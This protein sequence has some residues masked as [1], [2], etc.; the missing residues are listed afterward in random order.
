MTSAR[1]VAAI[2]FLCVAAIAQNARAVAQPDGTVIPQG[3]NVQNLFMSRSEPLNAL[4]D[5]AITPERFV[6]GC[7]LTFTLVTRD[8]ALFQNAFGWY[9]VDPAGRA[10]PESDLHVLIPCSAR[11]PF[12]ATLD[13]RTEAAY[14]GGEIGFFL[15]TPQQPGSTSSPACS[16][17][18][19]CGRAGHPGY[20]YYTQRTYN[21]DNTGPSSYIHLLIYDSRVTPQAFYFAWEDLYGGGDNQF[22]DFVA[23]VSNIV[24]AGAGAACNTGRPGVCGQGTQQCRSGMLTCVGTNTPRMETCDGADN[25]CDGRVDNGDLCPARFVCERGTCVAQCVEGSCFDGFA[26]NVRA[27]CVES[28]CLTVDCAEGQR[29]EAGRCVGVCDGVRCPA[30][31]LCRAGRC[32][33][34]C[35]GVMCDMDQ[36]CV[37]GVCQA[38]CEC[39]RC[40]TGETCASSG[41]CVPTACATVTCPA[42]ET[43]AMGACT[44]ACIGV[45]CPRG[46]RCER[47]ACVLAPPVSGMDGGTS[48]TGV[49]P[50]ND[51]AGVDVARD[52]RRDGGGLVDNQSAC[53]CRIV[54]APSRPP[55]HGAAW[56]ALGALSVSFARRGCGR[57]TR[58]C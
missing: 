15:R 18:D 3:P 42:G 10:P 33:D 23:L 31:Q 37:D 7:R 47:G 52:A 19:C 22:T 13:L 39:R 2:T 56:I 45:M 5:A 41:R 40:A 12:V 24:C 4:T 55:Q 9:N 58:P 38:R 20:T 36:V 29:C 28:A 30:G 25:D 6:P 35:T 27:R 53:G 16:G 48:D 14:R 43:C 32:A 44:D 57:R 17:G 26:C 21:P 49:V 8:V 46:E 50:V 11:P 1:R 34:P 51:A 54:G